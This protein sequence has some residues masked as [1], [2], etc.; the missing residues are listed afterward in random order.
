M[1]KLLFLS[2]FALFALVSANVFGQN[3]GTGAAPSIGSV[4]EYWVNGNGDGS[5]QTSGTGNTYSWWISKGGNNLTSIET[6]GDATSEFSVTGGTYGATGTSNNYKIGLRFNPSAADELYYLVVKETSS[7]N[8]YNIKAFA[9]QPKNNFKIIFA[10]LE[11]DG[12][13]GDDLSRCAPDITLSASG[14]DINYN[15]GSDNYQFKLI[16]S[17]V[18]TSWTFTNTFENVLHSANGT[19][20]YKIGEGAT[21]SP[22]SSS[23]TVPA[24]PNGAEVVYFKVDVVN[25]SLPG[26]GEEGRDGQSMKLTLTDIKDAGGVNTAK[27]FK[28][29]G[30]TEFSGSPVQNQTVKARPNTTGIQ[31]N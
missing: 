5:S 7:D 25:G 4:H 22:Y 1:K 11:S 9:I 28:S 17:G 26:T 27:V 6:P 8:C 31:S 3:Q 12:T 15:Y 24:N 21:W 16:A 29:N 10:A 23:V 30:T 19:L 20:Q 18:Y 2:I 14:T 13:E